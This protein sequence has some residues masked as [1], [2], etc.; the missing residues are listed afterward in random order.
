[1][2]LVYTHA[3]SIGLFSAFT[4]D[5][6]VNENQ[7]QNDFCKD[8][9]FNC[10]ELIW[11][12]V[13]TEITYRL[14]VYLCYR[15]M[16]NSSGYFLELANRCCI[17]VCKIDDTYTVHWTVPVA[18]TSICGIING[19]CN[20]WHDDKEADVS[21]CKHAPVDNNRSDFTHITR[22]VASSDVILWFWSQSISHSSS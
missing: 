5:D 4:L 19:F 10:V 14:D 15:Y 6:E 2:A 8:E 1:M 9:F 20:T 11:I 3:G 7:I 13:F 21:A 18:F 17:D 12:R 22:H 16:P